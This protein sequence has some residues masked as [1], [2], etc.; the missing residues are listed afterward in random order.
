LFAVSIEVDLGGILGD[1]S[2]MDGGGIRQ[3]P[4]ILDNPDIF[5]N[6]V[7]PLL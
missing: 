4:I 7:D 1:G 5:A 3:A 2:E 6:L